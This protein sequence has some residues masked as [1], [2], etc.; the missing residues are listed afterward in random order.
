MQNN[1]AEN[2]QN[3]LGQF[4]QH[5]FTAFTD[6]LNKFNL[7]ALSALLMTNRSLYAQ[8]N[9]YLFQQNKK[10]ALDYQRGW[11][12]RVVRRPDYPLLPFS[13]LNSAF[14]KHFIERTDITQETRFN[15]LLYTARLERVELSLGEEN[16][17]FIHASLANGDEYYL[18]ALHL[19]FPYF[20]STQLSV[21]E[22]ALER[23]EQKINDFR[24]LVFNSLI[25]KDLT[26]NS[27]VILGLLTKNKLLHPS[28]VQQL[29]FRLSVLSEQNI[30]MI[31]QPLIDLLPY[32]SAQ[33]AQVIFAQIILEEL[34]Y[35]SDTAV[36]EAACKLIVAM[37][38]HIGGPELIQTL[39]QHA[40]KRALITHKDLRAEVISKVFLPHLSAKPD[41]HVIE[42]ILKTLREKNDLLGCGTACYLVAGLTTHLQIEQILEIP[43]L[44]IDIIMNKLQQKNY[45][46][47]DSEHDSI[48]FAVVFAFKKLLSVVTASLHRLQKYQIQTLFASVLKMGKLDPTLE[49]ND[50]A[51]MFKMDKAIIKTFIKFVPYLQVGQIKEFFA[52]WRVFSKEYSESFSIGLKLASAFYEPH[53]HFNELFVSISELLKDNAAIEIE[54]GCIM[55][56]YLSSGFS[57]VQKKDISVSVTELIKHPSESVRSVAWQVLHNMV[58]QLR[59]PQ[60]GIQE[61]STLETNLHDLFQEGSVEGRERGFSIIA[62]LL[63]N[64]HSMH[65][66]EKIS[67]IIL[68]LVS[69]DPSPNFE[70]MTT[71][72]SFLKL[73]N[74]GMAQE[75]VKGIF[76]MLDRNGALDNGV[77]QVILPELETN[78]ILQLVDTIQ[79]GINELDVAPY[80]VGKIRKMLSI[81]ATYLQP[82]QLQPLVYSL[83]LQLTFIRIKSDEMQSLSLTLANVLVI[84][85]SKI[86]NERA[87]LDKVKRVFYPFR[88]LITFHGWNLCACEGLYQILTALLPELTQEELLSILPDITVLSFHPV[89]SAASIALANFLY[90]AMSCLNFNHE[91]VG[92]Q[93][94]PPPLLIVLKGN[95]C[96]SA[97]D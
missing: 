31:H 87:E 92:L 34:V 3:F 9:L 1:L 62:L 58:I 75:T 80:H 66:F 27:L 96:L 40:I 46:D 5:Y 28:Q 69:F 30:C 24:D 39:L 56:L 7:R 85:L 61:I 55:A 50:L 93:H 79:L 68:D 94:K 11:L 65:F 17:Q 73:K 45:T 15:S 37:L 97:E 54:T 95:A 72:L 60:I 91:R 43:G 89:G 63:P 84:L 10:F 57:P 4:S 67:E 18:R 12:G 13:K 19:V 77:L 76:E 83:T 32:L 26:E 48:A 74:R 53:P 47:E 42:L 8:V 51:L 86:N 6:I 88:D 81:V 35:S 52:Q 2:A 33:Q 38:P 90:Q 36:C 44:L 22:G 70:T 78:Q 20:L 23:E 64:F 25:Q 49:W 16:L 21:C 71:Y 41:Q 14:M 59:I 82:K 29:Y